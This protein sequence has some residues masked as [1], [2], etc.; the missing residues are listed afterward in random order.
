MLWQIPMH[1]DSRDI[2]RRF[3]NETTA[4]YPDSTSS[5]FP[6]MSL[7]VMRLDLSLLC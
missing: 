7:G 6:L 3:Y 5:V 2:Q 4:E 1:F